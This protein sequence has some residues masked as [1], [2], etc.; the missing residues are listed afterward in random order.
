MNRHQHYLFSFALATLVVLSGCSSKE[1]NVLQEY[2]KP[3]VYDDEKVLLDGGDTLRPVR[4]QLVADT[5]FVSYNNQPRIDVY[6]REFKRISSVNLTDPEPI[7][8][9]SFYVIDSLIIV[10]A[11]ARHLIIVYDRKGTPLMSFGTLPDGTSQLSPFAVTY[12]G[13]VAYIADAGLGQI[14]A[15]SLVN[16]ENITE[17]GEL[18]LTI[19]KDSTRQIGFPSALA[20]TP[21]G[22]LIVG[23]AKDGEINVFTCDGGY[24]YDFD[25]VNENAVMAPRGF[26]MDRVLDPMVQDSSSFDPSGIRIQGRLHVVDANNGRIHMFNPSGKYISSYPEQR[27]PGKPSDIAIDRQNLKIY[28]ADPGAARIFIY[29]Y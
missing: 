24:I 1:E 7:Y 23:D 21:D 8:P 2:A 17:V 27:L 13:G 11:H 19:P 14:L 25:R 5:I 4:L 15:V 9:T 12:F 26:A 3:P 18:I 22:R 28:I 10:A 16:A 6:N 29:N 20:V